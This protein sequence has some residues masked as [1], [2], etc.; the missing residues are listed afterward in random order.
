M[1]SVWPRKG[2]HAPSMASARRLLR[3]EIRAFVARIPEV[4]Q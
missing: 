4:I 1:G 2:G 3:D